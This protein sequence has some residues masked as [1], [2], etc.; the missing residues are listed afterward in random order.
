M[1]TSIGNTSDIIII[2]DHAT[3]AS[4]VYAWYIPASA[5]EYTWTIGPTKDSRKVTAGGI[6]SGNN[7]Y[8]L[9]DTYRFR[10]IPLVGYT[11]ITNLKKALVYWSAKNSRLY[12][13]IKPQSMSSQNIA[14]VARYTDINQTSGAVTLSQFTGKLQNFRAGELTDDRYKV[15]IDMYYEFFTTVGE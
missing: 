14:L 3:P 1:V 13:S 4:G 2:S 10:D 15:N 11:D 9:D 7:V 12:L 6:S 8:E 5:M